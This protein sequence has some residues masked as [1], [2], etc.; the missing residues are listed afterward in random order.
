M[1]DPDR[2]AIYAPFIVVAIPLVA[3]VLD[4][5]Q[6]SSNCKAMRWF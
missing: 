2:V 5:E 3:L 1:A 6:R 4:T